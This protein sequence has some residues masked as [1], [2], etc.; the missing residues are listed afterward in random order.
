[1]R[2]VA[3]TVLAAVIGLTG[4]GL[5]AAAS[6]QDVVIA[7]VPF[8]FVS[9]GAA[10]PAGRY[11]FKVMPR[12]EAVE[13][14]GPSKSSGMVHVLSRLGPAPATEMDGRLI[15]DKVGQNFYL[16]E[17]WLPERDGFL[18]YATKGAHTH[19]SVTLEGGHHAG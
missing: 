6:A 15:F 12:D 17:L 14:M 5:G 2:A 10:H 9:G 7:N 13:F 1:M 19:Q 11:E 3:R 18:M 16:S 8:N 4:L